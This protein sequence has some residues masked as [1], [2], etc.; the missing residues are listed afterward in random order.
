MST[1]SSRAQSK[2]A[3]RAGPEAWKAATCPGS[4]W[5]AGP[6][7]PWRKGIKEE[8]GHT[9]R[10][11]QPAMGGADSTFPSAADHVHLALLQARHPTH[12]FTTARQG[13]CTVSLGHRLPRPQ[14]SPGQQICTW[15]SCWPGSMDLYGQAQSKVTIPFL[16][17]KVW[18]IRSQTRPQF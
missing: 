6:T 14:H 10:A 2:L 9:A 8:K 15:P 16:L 5:H 17:R 12:T 7:G 13:T 18:T 11:T 4:Q 1:N 3:N